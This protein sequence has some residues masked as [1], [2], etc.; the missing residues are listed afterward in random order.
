[1]SVAFWLNQHAG[2]TGF[3]SYEWTSWLKNETLKRLTQFASETHRFLHML[4]KWSKVDTQY[5]KDKSNH[6]TTVV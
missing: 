5:A 4:S 1:M 3:I 2:G 6:A